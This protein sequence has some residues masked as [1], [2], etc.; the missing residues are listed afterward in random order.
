LLGILLI[1]C[2][3]VSLPCI[4]SILTVAFQ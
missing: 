1:F 4:I 3:V 2:N